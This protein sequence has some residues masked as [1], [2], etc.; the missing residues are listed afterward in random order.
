MLERMAEFNPAETL[1]AILEHIGVVGDV[2]LFLFGVSV[3]I[4]W[5]LVTGCW[6]VSLY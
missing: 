2:A 1:D 3:E 4:Y 5:L 6:F